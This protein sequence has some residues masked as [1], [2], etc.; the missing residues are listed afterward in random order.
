MG[1]DPPPQPLLQDAEAWADTLHFPQVR[2]SSSGYRF[3]RTRAD[4]LA[5][6]EPGRLRSWPG[7]KIESLEVHQNGP[8]GGNVTVRYSVLNHEGEPL[9]TYDRYS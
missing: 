1:D 6:P 2:L 3:W 8:T 5:G 9:A 4:F 7:A